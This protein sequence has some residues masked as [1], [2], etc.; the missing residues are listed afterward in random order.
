MPFTKTTESEGHQVISKREHED[1]EAELERRGTD[2]LAKV[3][4]EEREE[5][6]KQIQHA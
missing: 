1:I 5:L 4:P 2:R 6:L 3:A